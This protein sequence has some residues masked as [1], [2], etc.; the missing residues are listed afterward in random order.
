MWDHNETQLA[1][2]F[3]PSFSENNGEKKTRIGDKERPVQGC[4]HENL[5][6]RML[7]PGSR[8]MGVG[9]EDLT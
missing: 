6:S 3:P 5:A 9:G 1:V 8:G 4:E 7:F 2:F